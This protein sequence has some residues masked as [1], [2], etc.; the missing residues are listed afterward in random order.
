MRNRFDSVEI[1]DGLTG[2]LIGWWHLESLLF[3][4]SSSPDRMGEFEGLEFHLHLNSAYKGSIR[5][6]QKD[7][8]V[9]HYTREQSISLPIFQIFF[10]QI[11][12]LPPAPF[13]HRLRGP[14]PGASFRTESP[15]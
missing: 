7:G 14:L 12:I 4:S 8:F 10:P 3:R 11:H 5:W 9:H 15:I 6:P 13:L 2:V 1:F